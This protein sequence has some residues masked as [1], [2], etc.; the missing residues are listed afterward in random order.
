ME[1]LFFELYAL[2]LQGREF[3]TDFLDGIVDDWIEPQATGDRDAVNG[4]FERQ[5]ELFAKR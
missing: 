3:A 4:A 1:R 2:G 5:L